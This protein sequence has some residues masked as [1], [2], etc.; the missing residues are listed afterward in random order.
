LGATLASRSSIAW[1]HRLIRS[2]GA[3]AARPWRP[4]ITGDRGTGTP[5]P[6]QESK[7]KRSVGGQARV[8]RPTP[9]L[10]CKARADRKDGGLC[11]LQLL[12]RRQPPNPQGGPRTTSEP[13]GTLENSAALSNARGDHDAQLPRQPRPRPAGVRSVRGYTGGTR[14]GKASTDDKGNLVALRQR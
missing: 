12:V 10:S 8:I 6:C 5:L 1:C 14:E 11:L 13:P 9:E 2:A 7:G 4:R 3:G